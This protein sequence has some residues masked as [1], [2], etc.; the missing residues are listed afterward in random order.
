MIAH[1]IAMIAR[2]DSDGVFIEPKHFEP[3]QDTT[4]GI[5]DHRN[6]AV[7][8]RNRLAYLTLGDG[9]CALA[10]SIGAILGALL[11]KGLQMGRDRPLRGVKRSWQCDVRRVVHVPIPTRRRKRMMWVGERALKEERPTPIRARI[12]FQIHHRTF[13]NVGGWIELFGYSRA[14]RLRRDIVVPRQLI[15]STAERV[16][17]GAA[18]L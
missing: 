1:E 15:S 2:D 6:H 7:G 4:D 16:G 12:M 3:T 5:I 8:K 9:E 10:V 11:V 18:L 13:G 14:P 17:V